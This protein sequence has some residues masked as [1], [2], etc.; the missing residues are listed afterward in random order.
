MEPEPPTRVAQLDGTANGGD[1]FIDNPYLHFVVSEMWAALAGIAVYA[2]FHLGG[3]AT[4]Y[5]AEIFP[6]KDKASSLFLEGTLSWAGA[7]TASAT[8][9]IVSVY[10]II[11]LVK[12]L[13]ERV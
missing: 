1:A 13:W 11:V 12:R 9:I 3:Y 5:I 6:L 4:Q 7:L 8:F 2:F 10:Q